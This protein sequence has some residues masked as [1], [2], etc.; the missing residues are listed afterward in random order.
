MSLNWFV[1]VCVGF[2]SF[3]LVRDCLGWLGL[4]LSG[5]GWLEM[6]WVALGCLCFCCCCF[7]MVC[8]GFGWF[9]LV[10]IVFAGLLWLWAVWVG[11]NSCVDV[12]ASLC[13]AGSGQWLCCGLA[14][15]GL[16]LA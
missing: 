5:F 16:G 2:C 13:F 14:G 6:V 8:D 10:C 1:L 15:A 11:L 9:G 7:V 4:I 3:A 12:S